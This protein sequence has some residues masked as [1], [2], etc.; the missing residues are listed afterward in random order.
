[1]RILLASRLQ[2]RYR[3]APRTDAPSAVITPPTPTLS[4]CTRVHGSTADATAVTVGPF[5]ITQSA[6]STMGAAR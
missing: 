6:I 1:M 3:A 2:R 4:T 5:A